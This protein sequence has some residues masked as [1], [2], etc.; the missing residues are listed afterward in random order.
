MMALCAPVLFLFFLFVGFLF[1]HCQT[2]LS[3]SYFADEE[4]IAQ[5]SLG[6]L[7]REKCNDFSA[8]AQKQ[9][10]CDFGFSSWSWP[11]ASVMSEK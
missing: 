9:Q 11:N 8:C 7:V 10:F 1:L 4:R 5:G 6:C 3:V 2:V